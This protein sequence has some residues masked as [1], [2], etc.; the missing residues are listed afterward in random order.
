MSRGSWK[1]NPTKEAQRLIDAVEA[2]GYTVTSV[3]IANGSVRLGLRRHGEPDS[4]VETPLR[5]LV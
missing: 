3:E 4:T 2:K 5:E 1:L